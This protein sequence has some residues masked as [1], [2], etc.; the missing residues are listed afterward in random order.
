MSDT[1]HT[2]GPCSHT[3]LDTPFCPHCGEATSQ[4]P[5]TSLLSHVNKHVYLNKEALSSTLRYMAK[6]PSYDLS[7][8][9]AARWLVE[10]EEKI[11]AQTRLRDK[12]VRW[13]SSLM[14]ILAE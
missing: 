4:E 7:E 2:P 9:V 1:K 12:W 10:V 5:L 8:D 14:E 6:G 13:Q 3:L 11:A